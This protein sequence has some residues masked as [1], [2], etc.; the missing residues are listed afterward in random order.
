MAESSS[1]IPQHQKQIQQQDQP[2]RPMKKYGDGDVTLNTTQVFSVN[3]WALKLNQPDGPWFIDHT[4]AICAGDVHV[5]LASTLVD[6]GMHKEDQQAVGGPTSLGVTSEEGAHPQLSSGVLASNLN[7]PIFSASF[8]I[9]SESA[10]GRDALVDSTGGADPG[11]SAP[12]KGANLEGDEFTRS[13]E[14]SMK[15]KL[16]DLSKLVQNVKDDFMDLDS[17]K[18]DLIIMVDESEEDKEDKDKESQKYKLENKKRQAEAEVAL[19]SAKPS[20]PNVE[21]LTKLLILKKFD[22][23]T[24]DGD[25]VYLTEEQIKEQ[26]RIEESSKAEAAKHEV[27]V[28]KEELVDLLGPVVVSKYYKAKLQYD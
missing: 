17:L 9:H 26:K 15:I 5:P 13:N 28:R 19:L 6:V 10:S 27:E 1:Q 25:H 4:M 16:E 12:R 3:N 14:I 8:I 21:Q 2:E 23:V 22:F 20:F 11:K 24:E 7:K 18:D